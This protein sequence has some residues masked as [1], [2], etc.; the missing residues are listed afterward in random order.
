MKCV[1]ENGFRIKFSFFPNVTCISVTNF[2]PQHGFIVIE[3]YT[4]STFYSVFLWSKT[5]WKYFKV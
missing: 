5:E 3:F 2:L 4:V 1:V